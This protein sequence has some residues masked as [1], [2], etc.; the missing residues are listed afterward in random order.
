MPTAVVIDGAFFLRQFRR[1]FPELDHSKPED[2]ASAIRTLVQYHLHVR[3]RTTEIINFDPYESSALYRVFF[4][5][6]PP[7]EKK[8]HQPVSKRSIDL[9][10]TPQAKLRNEIHSVLQNVRKV[11]LRLGRLN[12]AVSWRIKPAAVE[13]MLKNPSMYVPSDDDFEI[14]T[15]QKGVDMRLGL[16]VAA[17]A[18]KKQVDQIV[19]VASDADFVPAVKLARREGIDVVLDT[20]GARAADDLVRH[21]DGIRSYAE[22]LASRDS[23]RNNN[24][25]KFS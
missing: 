23:P 14:D 8:L 16:D 13:M 24:L 7:L 10:K 1:N 4:Y 12:E 11:A 17:M 25:N 9:A 2:I 18:F 21:V 15:Q 3:T 19:I 6:C 20:M 5:D 22:P